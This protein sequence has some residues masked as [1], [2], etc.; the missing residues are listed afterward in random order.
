[1]A[2]D[3]VDLHGAAG[4]AV[5][6]GDDADRKSLLLEHR[7]LLDMNFDVTE[8]LVRRERFF[9]QA[10]RIGTE[11]LQCLAARH[12]V[13]AGFVEGLEIEPARQRLGAA[14]RRGKAHALF[15]AERDD[16]DGERK[17]L[18]GFERRL[19]HFDGDDDAERAVEPAGVAHGV[20]V[21]AKDQRQRSGVARAIAADD[22]AECIDARSSCPPRASTWRPGRRRPDAPAR[23]KAA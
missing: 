16:F 3:A 2:G 12:A 19:H 15:I 21:G 8:R 7:P 1:M 5:D 4:D 9:G 23:D 11:R 13:V 6:R 20:D 22:A 10:R 18:A 17:S 14:E